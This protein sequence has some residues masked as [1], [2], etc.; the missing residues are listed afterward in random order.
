MLG[1]AWMRRWDGVVLHSDESIVLSRETEK[2]SFFL[3]KVF[4]LQRC[5]CNCVHRTPP[6]KR[7]SRLLSSVWIIWSEQG[8]KSPPPCGVHGS[9]NWSVCLR[10]CRMRAWVS[11]QTKSDEIKACACLARFAQYQ[12][13]SAP[14]YC[15]L[16]YRTYHTTTGSFTA[17]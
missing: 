10:A 16:P 9:P 13:R 1:E 17:T 6:P 3:G 15:S 2:A 7:N 5:V 11:T 12:H 8:S 14:V 4:K